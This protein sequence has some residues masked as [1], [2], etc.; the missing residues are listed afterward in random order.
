MGVQNYT[1]IQIASCM[2]ILKSK[3]CLPWRYFKLV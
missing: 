2:Y 1:A 3:V